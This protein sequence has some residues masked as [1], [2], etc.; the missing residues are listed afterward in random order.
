ML[1]HKCSDV[2]KCLS[3]LFLALT[4]SHTL[5]KTSETPSRYSNRTLALLLGSRVILR[6]IYF[7]L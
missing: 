7:S 1:L 4:T 5:Q 2:K 6:P 3:I